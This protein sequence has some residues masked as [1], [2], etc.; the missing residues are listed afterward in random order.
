MEDDASCLELALRTGVPLAAL[1]DNV[2]RAAR[3]VDV[4]LVKI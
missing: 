1:D 3:L 2:K 4:S